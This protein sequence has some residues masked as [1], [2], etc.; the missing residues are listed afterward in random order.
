M[1][2]GTPLV[3]TLVTSTSTDM[4]ATGITMSPHASTN[5]GDLMVAFTGL[6]TAFNHIYAAGTTG[7]TIAM[8]QSDGAGT[9]RSHSIQ[10]KYAGASEGSSNFKTDADN[11]SPAN[12][13]L[14][15][16]F[17]GGHASTPL[18]VTYADG[19]HHT[20]DTNIP[21][22]NSTIHNAITTATDD[23]YVVHYMHANG[24]VAITATAVS[25]GYTL[26]ASQIADDLYQYLIQAKVVVTAGTETPDAAA[27]TA[28]SSLNDGSFYTIALRGAGAEVGS[29][30]LSSI[31]VGK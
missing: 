30:M 24:D 14:I 22:P 16:T 27:F 18:D 2:W 12:F 28:A 20:E 8:S 13:G 15:I 29:F 31:G 6:R 7:W 19:T 23:A 21:T 4:L 26:L 10:T 1:T 3:G 9:N 5:E 17:P 25:T 11:D